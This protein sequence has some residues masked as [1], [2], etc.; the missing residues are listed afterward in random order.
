GLT[1][2]NNGAE[3]AIRP[4]VIGRKNFLFSVST[5]GADSSAAIYSLIETAKLFKLVPYQY[6]QYIFEKLPYAESDCDYEK[7]L[8]WNLNI[9]ELLP[10]KK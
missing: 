10:A 3:N 7:L 4:F 2:S 9:E 5:K 6:L 1:P 8:P